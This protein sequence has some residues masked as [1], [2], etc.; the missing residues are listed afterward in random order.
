ML[1]LSCLEY[2]AQHTQHLQRL[3]NSNP[4]TRLVHHTNWTG[5]LIPPTSPARSNPEHL[6]TRHNGCRQ[7]HVLIQSRQTWEWAGLRLVTN[8]RGHLRMRVIFPMG[9]CGLGVRVGEC[10]G[11]DGVY[12]LLGEVGGRDRE[13]G[14]VCDVKRQLLGTLL[15]SFKAD[16]VP[17]EQKGSFPHWVVRF[18]SSSV[19]IVT[20]CPSQ[21]QKL[22]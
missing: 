21:V 10:S 22:P 8:G 13:E 15:L 12:C 9:R 14:E 11:M 1:T 18:G 2:T 17:S 7:F 19:S 16:Q 20:A 4:E 5:F 6:P 3:K